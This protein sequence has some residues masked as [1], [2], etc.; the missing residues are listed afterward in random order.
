MYSK[1][2]GRAPK[3][4]VGVESFRGRL[5]IRLPRH[6]YGGKQ[7]YLSTDLADTDINRRVV[8][9]KAKLMESDIA[10]ERFDYTLVK[11]GKPKPP[12]LT[13]LEPIRSPS[14]KVI[15]LW[16]RYAADKRSGLKAKTQEKYDNLTRLYKKLGDVT[17]DEPLI[18][19]NKLEQI[20]TI[21]RTKDGLMYLAAACR[22]GKKHKLVSSNPFEGMAQELPKYRYQVDPKPNSFTEEE[23]DQVVEEFRSDRRKGM[24]YSH[25]APFV[26]FLFCVGCR[27]S[28]AIGL[29]WKHVSE[30]SGSISFEGS[31]VQIGNRRV[32]SKGSKNN[33]TRR[34][35]VSERV[36]ALLASIRP[37]NPNPDQ[38]V[39]PSRD[40]D[41]ISYRNFSRRA[42]AKIVN[43]IK[44]DT[45]PY[46]CRDTFITIQLIK[47]VPSTVIAKWCDTS[48]QMI[49]QNYADKL[50]LS[51]IRPKD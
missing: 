23:R 48:T 29:Q 14:M 47:G 15:E 38:L 31:L 10:L 34:I 16:E 13:L 51:Q 33:K 17:I 21:Y 4:S 20:T 1:K 45:T 35:A 2:P 42:W 28:E 40:G 26:E 37:E 11:Y 8:E 30:D 43:P 9:A 3:G 24:N 50:K 36:R 27:P 18:I 46:C 25:Y 7:K 41:S 22:W 49:D 6:L 32:R 12:Q 44:P 5:R 39:F 19:K